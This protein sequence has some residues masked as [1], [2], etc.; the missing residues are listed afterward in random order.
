MDSTS[1][2]AIAFAI[3]A[4]AGLRTF[5]AP[6]VVSWAARLNWLN[7]QDTWLAF[8]G[9]SATPYVLTLIYQGCR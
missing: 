6:M 4:I 2:F 3:G 7:L 1:V 5:T 9:Y 8:L